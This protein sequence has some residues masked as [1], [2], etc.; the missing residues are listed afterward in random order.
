MYKMTIFKELRNH[1]K[2]KGCVFEVFALPLAANLNIVIQND[3]IAI[4][5]D[6][7]G[8]NGNKI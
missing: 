5:R 4:S 8:Q 7:I 2:V 3:A 6:L 1:K